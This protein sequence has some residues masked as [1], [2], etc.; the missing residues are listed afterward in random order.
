MLCIATQASALYP[1]QELGAL[2]EFFA[3]GKRIALYLARISPQQTIDHLAYETS[4]ALL[5]EDPSNGSNSGTHGSNSSGF[6]PGGGGGWRGVSVGG[7]VVEVPLE[8]TAALRDS[9]AGE[10]GFV[11]FENDAAV[12]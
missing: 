1:P 8:F 10:Q 12:Q 6:G 2:M 4:L 11:L 3:V 7:G 9:G 5:E